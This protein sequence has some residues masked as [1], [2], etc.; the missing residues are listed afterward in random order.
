VSNPLQLLYDYTWSLLEANEELA[1]LVKLGNRIK[2]DTRDSDKHEASSADRPQLRLIS[3]GGVNHLH[4]TSN[5]SSFVRK[6]EIQV[7]SGTQKL[8][9]LFTLEWLLYRALAPWP[10]GART[11]LWN[12]KPFVKT[13]KPTSVDTGVMQSEQ[14]RTIKDWSSLWAVECELW[15]TT[16]DLYP[17]EE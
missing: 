16:S 7:N 17:E 4:R 14:N 12:E 10:D 9:E 2:F 8:S 11:L 6:L 15:F 13:I 5:G 3:T 1:E